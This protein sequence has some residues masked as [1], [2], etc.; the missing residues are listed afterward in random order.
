MQNRVNKPRVF[1]SHSARDK[2]FIER[3]A[4]DL[5]KC[6]IDPWLD[7]EE[8][9]DGK[10]WLKVIFEDG[11]PICDAV[12]IYLTPN[13]LKSKMVTKELDATIVEQL[14]ERSISIL[15]YVSKAELRDDLR[16]DVK[17]LH[18]REW[19][20]SNYSELLPSVVAEIWRS[21]LERTISSAILQERNKR[22]ELEIDLKNIREKFEASVFTDMEDRE[23]NYIQKVLDRSIEVTFALN[24]K[25]NNNPVKVGTYVYR[26]NLLRAVMKHLNTGAHY[27]DVYEFQNLILQTLRKDSP[28][29]RDARLTR[30]IEREGIKENLVLELKTYDFVRH[31]QRSRHD[32]IVEAH[33]FTDKIYRFKYWLGYNN[34]KDDELSFELVTHIDIPVR[35]PRPRII[36]DEEV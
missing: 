31:T 21:Y 22:L 20:E 12:L 13:S 7:T 27:F 15:P 29:E 8:V 19:N 32:F 4:T 10:P 24:Q 36:L 23:F 1:L 25:V 34:F 2:G 6:Q 16:S 9:R 26:I 5:R 30:D 11:I 28:L 33:E 14:G 3:L 35:P 18:C 17:A